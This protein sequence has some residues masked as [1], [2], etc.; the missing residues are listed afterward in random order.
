MDRLD[1]LVPM[2][3]KK[4]SDVPEII[5]NLPISRDA[6]CSNPTLGVKPKGNK[7]SKMQNPWRSGGNPPYSFVTKFLKGVY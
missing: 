3:T 2:D 7:N 5:Q 6:K 1:K 4:S